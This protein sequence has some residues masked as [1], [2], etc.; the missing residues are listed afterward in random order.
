MKTSLLVR[1]ALVTSLLIPAAGCAVATDSDADPEHAATTS[2][3][4]TTPLLL[5]FNAPAAIR[6]ST[7]NLYWTANASSEF[8]GY[9]AK[10]FR[11]SKS[12]TPGN[13]AV[14]YAE[15]SST[16]VTFGALTYAEVNGTFFAYFVANYGSVSQ[17][18]RVPLTGG[19]AT[20]MATS[21]ASIG[22]RQTLQT[23]AILPRGRVHDRLY[24]ADATGIRSMPLVGGAITTLASI[25]SVT[26]LVI[27]SDLAYVASGSTIF[28]IPKA[29][30]TLQARAAGASTI[31]SLDILPDSGSYERQS[32]L[33]WSELG[34]KVF[35]RL[36]H[37]DLG[38]DGPNQNEFSAAAGFE[39]RSTSIFRRSGALGLTWTLC[40]TPGN[41]TCYT[42]VKT[43]FD[44]TTPPHVSA[45]VGASFVQADASQVFWGTANDMRR[46]TY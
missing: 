44:T 22:T 39:V 6:Q 35:K 43:T 14:L 36:V 23:D 32:Y 21:P 2:E 4:L 1:L 9:T 33:V 34:G 8:G 29:G 41:S 5:S 30:G 26:N 38:P 40:T 3:A 24:W 18:K 17:I 37:L 31:T 12:N 28:T 27:D 16:P 10:V 11:A 15:A 45:G 7:G 13:E 46:S 20:V 42:Y 19:T 25:S